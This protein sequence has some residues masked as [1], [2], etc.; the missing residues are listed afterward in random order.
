MTKTPYFEGF[1]RLFGRAKLADRVK[2]SREIER[3]RNQ[4]A[5]Q[6]GSVFSEVIEPEK[7]EGKKGWRARLFTPSMTL[8]C[9]IGQAF[10]ND[11]L[12]GAV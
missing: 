12:R 6:L 9:M 8:F 2:L 10:G 11:P 4:S 1:H 7:V 5:G 3:I